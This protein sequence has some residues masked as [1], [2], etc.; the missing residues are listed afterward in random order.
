MSLD[1]IEQERQVKINLISNDDTLE[2]VIFMSLVPR[3]GEKLLIQGVMYLITDVMYDVQ[4]V[5]VTLVLE[6]P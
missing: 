4:L 6:R 1:T 3:R 5:S 2:D